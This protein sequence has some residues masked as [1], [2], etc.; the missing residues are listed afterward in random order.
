MV[1]AELHN[2]PKVITNLMLFVRRETCSAMSGTPFLYELLDQ[3]DAK[4]DA[5]LLDLT[6]TSRFGLLFERDFLPRPCIYLNFTFS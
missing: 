5:L 2:V 6:P 1:L 4:S 3:E